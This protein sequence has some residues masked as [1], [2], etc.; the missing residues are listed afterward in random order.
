MKAI[1][2]VLAALLALLSLAAGG[3]KLAQTAQEI[4]FFASAGVDPF[5][6]YPL[7]GLQVIGAIACLPNA[8]RRLGLFVIAVGF[9]ISSAMIFVT[10]NT[11]FGAISLIP[12]LLA[13]V[14]GW[15][16]GSNEKG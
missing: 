6:L 10:G 13:L 3:A 9:A 5:W 4:E 15:R 8:T 7:G 12:A 1:G 14:L 16:L 11:M 2:L